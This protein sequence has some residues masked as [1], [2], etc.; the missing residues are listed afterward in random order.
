M[1]YENPV[2]CNLSL[3]LNDDYNE[4]SAIYFIL[5]NGLLFKHKKSNEG[6][7]HEVY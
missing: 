6:L 5:S 3:G 7:S 2:Q 1:Y 4:Y